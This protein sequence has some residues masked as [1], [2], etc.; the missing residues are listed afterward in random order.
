MGKPRSIETQ[1]RNLKSDYRRAEARIHQLRNS[2]T[3]AEA[4]RDAEVKRTD[5]AEKEVAEWKARFDALLARTPPT[6]RVASRR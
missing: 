3:E 4:E 1:L 2:L 5:A 6:E